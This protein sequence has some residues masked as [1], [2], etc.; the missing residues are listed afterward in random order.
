M[1]EEMHTF[2]TQ[3]EAEIM[4]NAIS[5]KNRLYAIPEN[6]HLSFDTLEKIVQRDRRHW[7][8]LPEAVTAYC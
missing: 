4:K 8:P 5:Q 2:Q 6:V 3:T 7:A 1:L